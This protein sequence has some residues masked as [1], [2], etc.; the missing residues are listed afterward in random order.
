MTS[1]V[2]DS[3]QKTILVVDDVPANVGLL[4]EY[5]E[6]HGFRALVA[7]DGE[8]GL[9]RA[10]FVQPD[11]IL[12]DVMM[13]NMDGFETC[14]R[15][16]ATEQIKDIPVIFM[17]ALT[18]TSDKVAG[19]AAGGVDYVTKPFQ[20]E[21]VIARINTHL[22]LR[23]AVKTLEMAQEELMRSDKLAALGALVAGIAHELN[24]PIGNSLLVVS[25]FVN[26]S[27]ALSNSYADNSLKRS[28]LEQYIKEGTEAGEI[29]VRNL[30]KAASLIASFKQVAV[31]QTSS[32]RRVF[33]LSTVIAEVIQTLSPSLGKS[34]F[35][36]RQSI[37]EDIVF[38]S[39]PGPL[40]QVVVNLVNNAVLH[41]F[42]GREAG[43]V[44]ISAQSSEV[45]WVELIVKDDGVGIQPVNLRRIF[46]P[47][48]TTKLGIGGSGLGLS[49]CHNIVTG[50]LG[51]RIRVES[52]EG[53]GT[54]FILNLPTSVPTH[55][56][57]SADQRPLE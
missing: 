27:R 29:L 47:F 28:V 18:D 49:I 41:G 26:Q 53:G 44:S 37:P 19:F 50:V 5:L 20:I 23:Q 12:L 45:G 22:A 34:S 46:D 43:V 7:Q 48:F 9:M 30:Q 39:Y 24:T 54:A 14:R 51:G 33:S 36:L 52:E 31:D 6:D 13:P 15:L 1:T 17:T 57:N 21:E 8:D 25:A 40:E 10:Q 55:I 3:Q 42:D 2:P 11:L 56:P 4:V 16:K 32:Q 38:D 35:A